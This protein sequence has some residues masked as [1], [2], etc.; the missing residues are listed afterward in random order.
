LYEQF[1]SGVP[2]ESNLDTASFRVWDDGHYRL[3]NYVTVHE[4]SLPSNHNGTLQFRIETVNKDGHRY[5][6]DFTF[7]KPQMYNE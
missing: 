4:F 3:A 5:K 7:N 2:W 1:R 6:R